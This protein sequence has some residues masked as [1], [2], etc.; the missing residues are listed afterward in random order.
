MSDPTTS[1]IALGWTPI[2]ALAYAS[3]L[4]HP[5]S[6][7]YGVARRIGKPTANT[8]KALISL[9]G[10]GAVTVEGGARRLY[11]AV[12]PGELLDGMER[13]FRQ[14]RETAFRGLAQLEPKRGDD[15]VHHLRTRDQ[16]VAR[17]RRML[18]RCR[19]AAL[20]E[21]P[22]SVL[23]RVADDISLAGDGGADV[24]IKTS[25]PVDLDGVTR[26]VV[27]EHTPVV[28][29]V[30]DSREMLLAALGPGEKLRHGVW[31]A[32]ADISALAHRALVAELLFA[33]VD[34]GLEQGI[35]ID[36]LEETFGAYARLR[37][38]AGGG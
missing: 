24:R 21:L 29:A 8:Y 38:L 16:L 5:R 25:Q 3:L 37:T 23:D 1:L 28:N 34:T 36:E 12:A 4:E 27:G 7:G 11:T 22:P 6:T 30:I 2:E 15:G 18:G 14:H 32:R 26:V 31:S 17:L 10:R 13:R 33:D 9:E 20:L 19:S 35:S